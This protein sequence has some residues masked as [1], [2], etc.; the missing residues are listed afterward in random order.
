VL[1][2]RHMASLTL[3]IS[4]E[5]VTTVMGPIDCPFNDNIVDVR[6]FVRNK[7]CFEASANFISAACG[8]V[9]GWYIFDLCIS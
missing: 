8:I 9:L 4:F 2:L 7:R 3:H 1:A 5:G 6:K